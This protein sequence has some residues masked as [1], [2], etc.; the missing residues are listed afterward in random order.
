[1]IPRSGCILFKKIQNKQKIVKEVRVLLSLL[2]LS[3]K[4]RRIKHRQ[5]NFSLMKLKRDQNLSAKIVLKILS[6]T[7][8]L[9]PKCRGPREAYL[10]FLRYEGARRD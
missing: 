2:L 10:C 9:A 6:S 7:L 4:I 8:K 3:N 5:R 1:M